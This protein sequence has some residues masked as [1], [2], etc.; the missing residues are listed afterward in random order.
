MANKKKAKKKPLAKGKAPS[1]PL[2]KAQVKGFEETDEANKTLKVAICIF[3]MVATFCIYSQIQDHEFIDFDDDKY[4]T[5]NLNVRAGLT[6]ESIKWAFTPSH[7]S[8]WHPMTWLSHMLDYQLYGLDPKGHYLTNLFL[9]ISSVLILFIV[10]LRMT[11][12]FWQ[13]GFVAAMF[14]FHPLIVHASCATKR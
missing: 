2:T 13:S 14:A 5:D 12:A 4:I 8:Y 11:G 10:L 3:L 1:S 9:H 6:I 7:T